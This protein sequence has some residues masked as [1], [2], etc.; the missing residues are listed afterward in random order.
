MTKGCEKA[1]S[2]KEQLEKHYS[3]CHKYEVK[4]LSRPI[5]PIHNNFYTT[6][7]ANSDNFQ[8]YNSIMHNQNM[9]YLGIF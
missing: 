7:M 5:E 9:S 8:N 1:F 4:Q 2:N 6:M 3:I